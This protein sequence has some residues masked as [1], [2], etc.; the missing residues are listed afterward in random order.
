MEKRKNRKVILGVIAAVLLIGLIIGG[1]YALDMIYYKETM[2]N[3]KI[4][5]VDL[6]D[7]R[8]GIYVGSCDARIISATVKVTVRDGEITGIELLEH[9]YDRGGPAVAIIDDILAE[10][11]L[12]VDVVSGATNSSK[13]ILK[14]VENALASGN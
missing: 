6:S 4:G 7:V 12:E 3:I 14:A 13:T 9:K 2:E 11:S 5:D 8:D 10:Q 1:K